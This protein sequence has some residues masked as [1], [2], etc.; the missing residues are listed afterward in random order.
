[1]ELLYGRA[2]RLTAQHGGFR[3]GQIDKLKLPPDVAGA[4]FMAAG[5]SAPELFVATAAIFTSGDFGHQCVM[6]DGKT[7]ILSS[8]DSDA[9]FDEMLDFSWQGSSEV[10]QACADKM[11]TGSSIHIDEGVGVG[12]VVGSTMFN[13]LCIIGGAARVI[14]D[15]RFRK[16]GTE[17]DRKPGMKWLSCTAK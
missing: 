1:M 11:A 16:T 12:A 8:V 15:C 3:L 9:G 13:T 5:S 6:N 2:G 7:L 14:P 17:Y 4:T 10:M